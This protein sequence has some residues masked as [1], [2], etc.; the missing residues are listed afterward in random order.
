[1][2]EMWN[3]AHVELCRVFIKNKNKK[4]PSTAWSPVLTLREHIYC[5]TTGPLTHR[6]ATITQPLCSCV[7]R[8]RARRAHACRTVLYRSCLGGC[9]KNREKNTTPSQTDTPGLCTQVAGPLRPAVHRW[10]IFYLAAAA[11]SSSSW[12]MQPWAPVTSS[13]LTLHLVCALKY[14]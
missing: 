13:R 10:Q 12:I 14:R 8:E 4:R 7:E 6:S 3:S 5:D 11:G 2:L 9:N 1:M